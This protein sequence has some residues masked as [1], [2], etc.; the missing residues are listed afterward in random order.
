MDFT[1]RWKTRNGK[2]A[3]IR[4]QRKREDG[5]GVVFVGQVYEADPAAPGAVFYW[6]EGGH[7]INGRIDLDIVERIREPN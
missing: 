5:S 7:E 1:G 6:N 4:P 2:T 3:V